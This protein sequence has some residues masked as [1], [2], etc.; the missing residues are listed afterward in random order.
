M[1]KRIKQILALALI[2]LGTLV[3]GW[4]LTGTSL[5]APNVPQDMIQPAQDG[6][7]DQPDE[8]PAGPS[9]NYC[10]LCH[11]RPDQVWVLPD[12][13]ELSLTIDPDVLKASVH[14]ENNPEGQLTC[15][16]CHLD[17]RYPHAEQIS[18]T[19]REFRAQRYAAC[20]T[21]HEDQYTHL[22]DSVHGTTL[23]QGRLDAATC[24]DCHG[25]HDI[26]P[27]DDP[28]QRISLT[29]GRCHGVIFEQY[30]NSVHGAALLDESNPDVPTCINCHGV[31]D[32]ANPTTD[33]FRVR[34]PELC[35]GCHADGDLMAQYD[36]STHISESYLT[37]FH[38]A[39]AALFEQED[40]DVVSNKAVCYDCHGVHNIQAVEGEGTAAIRENL[41][42]TCR[43]CHPDASANFSDA[44]IGHYEPTFSS[45]PLLFLVRNFYK[46][47]IP[48]VV[49]V[50]AILIGVDAI[51]GIRSRSGRGREQKS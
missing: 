9:D 8:E 12:G 13:A 26:Q 42:E 35:L 21:C 6:G 5:A 7:D 24:V 31:H 2:V 14:G 1:M 11:T 38:G 43:E 3:L 29:C 27:P 15:S 19:I 33:L 50:F 36:I 39:T 23:R 30:Q 48:G 4:Q 17:Y 32:I 45:N 18:Q 46:I 47:A 16:S 41:L 51:G 49:G 34:S 25:G 44:W 40:E 20:R 28:P 10:L 37:D 22:Q